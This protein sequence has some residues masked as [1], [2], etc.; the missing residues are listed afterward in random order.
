MLKGVMILTF[1][2]ISVICFIRTQIKNFWDETNNP[3][4]KWTGSLGMLLGIGA[5]SFV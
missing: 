2:I 3:I 5:F 4:P 1:V